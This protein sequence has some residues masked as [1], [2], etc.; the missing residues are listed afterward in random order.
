MKSILYFFLF[1]PIL[2]SAQLNESD[3]LQLKAKLALTGFWQTG[4]VET[5]IFRAKSELSIHPWK[6]WVFKTTNSYIYQ[7]F[8]KQK[9]DEDV[10]S[11]NFLYFNPKRSVY[12]LMLG[13][14]S[15]NHRREIDLRYLLGAGVSFQLLSHKDRWLKCSLTTEYEQTDFARADFN[16]ISYNDNQFIHTFRGTLWVGGKYHLLNRK[17]IVSHENWF[18]PSLT[19]SDNFRWQADIGLEIPLSKFL[20]FKTNYLHTF[21]SIVIANQ[22]RQD[23]ILSFG[24][25]VKNF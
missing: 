15:T 2:L 4:N 24:L 11:L 18:Q 19:Q 10:L 22:K 6:N 25:T 13:F 8:G 23:Q 16:H 5:L 7:E 20:N 9:A 12:P 21:E 14:I 1:F 17:V 3:T